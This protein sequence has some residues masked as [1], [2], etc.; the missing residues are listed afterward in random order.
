MESGTLDN[1]SGQDKLLG[2]YLWI[3][4]DGRNYTLLEPIQIRKKCNDIIFK[5]FPITVKYFVV[6]MCGHLTAESYISYIDVDYDNVYD[7]KIR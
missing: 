7:D 6:V 1:I 5:R 4:K 2:A 3:S